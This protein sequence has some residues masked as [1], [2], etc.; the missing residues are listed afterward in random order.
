[1]TIKNTGAVSIQLQGWVLS[2]A[3][4]NVVLPKRSV[5]A[6]DVVKVHSGKG[7]NNAGN[8]YLRKTDWFWA[9]LQ[10][11]HAGRR[12]RGRAGLVPRPRAVVIASN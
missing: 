3:D 2:D 5:G 4:S 8:L 12:R 6:G 11:H 10:H 1:M 7:T 9:R